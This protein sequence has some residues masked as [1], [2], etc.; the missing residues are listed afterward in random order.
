MTKGNQV[1]MIKDF[2]PRNSDGNNGGTTVSNN[3]EP[4]TVDRPGIYPN[5]AVSSC[6]V[7]PENE[8]KNLGATNEFTQ[9]TLVNNIDP[10][11][12]FCVDKNTKTSPHV[13]IPFWKHACMF[14]D[15]VEWVSLQTLKRTN[16]FGAVNC[17]DLSRLENPKLN[18]NNQNAAIIA[19]VKRAKKAGAPRDFWYCVKEDN[20]SPHLYVPTENRTCLISANENCYK[21]L[22]D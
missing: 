17:W 8:Y 3:N 5:I 20:T 4:A 10:K 16:Y 22:P 19:E 14:Q 21:G 12:E 7:L 13:Y 15:C 2:I 18:A 9:R 1:I 6:R 11:I